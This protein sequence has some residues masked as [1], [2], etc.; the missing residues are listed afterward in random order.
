[1]GNILTAEACET[2]V[3]AYVVVPSATGLVRKE[4][5]ERTCGKFAWKKVNGK[6][7]CKICARKGK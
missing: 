6:Y 2:I 7:T 5:P 1:M 3:R 4:L